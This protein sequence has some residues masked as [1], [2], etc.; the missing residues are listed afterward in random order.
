VAQALDAYAKE[1]SEV[2]LV[3]IGSSF[4]RQEWLA[5]CSGSIKRQ[6]IAVVNCGYEL[7]K[8]EWVMQNTKADR[9]LFLQDSWLIKDDHFF[10]LLD[11]LSGS[12]AIT[13]DPFYF[14]C[15]A[16]VYER[17]VIEQIGIPVTT[18]KRDAIAQEIEWHKSYVAVSG[19][20]TVLFPELTDANS[21]RQ[22]ERHGRTNLVLENNYLVKYKGTWS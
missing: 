18:G 4:D 20:P 19:E 17:A 21:T 22:E 7:G 9:F 13:S 1:T 6:H 12:V 10:T 8:I 14:G 16:G 15:Y 3:V 11:G 2:M 5:D